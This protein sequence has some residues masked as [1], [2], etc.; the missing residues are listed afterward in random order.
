M[1]LKLSLA[2]PHA[3]RFPAHDELGTCESSLVP[4][5]Q[6]VMSSLVGFGDTTQLTIT[7]CNISKTKTLGSLEGSDP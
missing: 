3:K 6:P 4:P 2:G 7:P 5:K 1:H